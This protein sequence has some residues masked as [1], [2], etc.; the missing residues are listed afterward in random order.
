METKGGK[1]RI[2]NRS[3]GVKRRQGYAPPMCAPGGRRQLSDTSCIDLCTVA[4][5]III[6]P[7]SLNNLSTS[8]TW[9][10]FI[11]ITQP[12]FVVSRR[13]GETAGSLSLLHNTPSTSTC[14]AMYQIHVLWSLGRMPSSTLSSP[15]G[16]W[17]RNSV[18]TL[19]RTMKS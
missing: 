13:S 17:R 5:I 16:V 1:K 2:S 14:P 12:Y 11:R 18:A 3:K 9:A 10:G 8:E 7:S 15:S 4:P 19:T 6:D